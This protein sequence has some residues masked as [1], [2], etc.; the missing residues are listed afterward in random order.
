MENPAEDMWQR[1]RIVNKKAPWRKERRKPFSEGEVICRLGNATSKE[2]GKYVLHGRE[3]KAG[4]L[5]PR[6]VSLTYIF[7]RF[8]GNV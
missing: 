3:R 4:I 7:S 2:N 8:G 6:K 5:M 1:M